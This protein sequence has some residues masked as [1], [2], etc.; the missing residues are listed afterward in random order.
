MQEL[1]EKIK[2]IETQIEAA[3]WDSE[4]HEDLEKALQT[5]QEAESR[6]EELGIGADNPAYPD[7]Q[8]V[9]SYCLMRQENILRQ[10]D[11]PQ[12]ALELGKREIAAA[13]ASG[14]EITL[15][16]ALMSNGTN[17][18]VSGK[19]DEGLKLLD[20]ARQVFEKGK[21]YDHKQGLGCYW[22]L[23]ADLANAGLVAKEPAEVIDIATRAL[24]ILTPI[25]NW[26]GVARGY[27]ARVAARQKLGDEEGA[28]KDRQEQEKYESKIEAEDKGEGY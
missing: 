26:P 20:G 2:A 6:L 24:E 23:Q 9:L 15:G 25:E 12:E 5:Y 10:L 3:L 19:M 14:D 7:Q 4:V 18:L 17:L 1:S 11:K 8:R 27:A 22:I 21:S 28:A 13:R 16:R